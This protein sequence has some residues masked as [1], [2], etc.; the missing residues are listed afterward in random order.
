MEVGELWRL[1]STLSFP[2]D[3]QMSLWS[4]VGFAVVNEVYV[5]ANQ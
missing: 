3:L 1:T 5:V 4:L 2:E